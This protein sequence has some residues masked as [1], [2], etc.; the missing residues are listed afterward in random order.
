MEFP[1]LCEELITL[2][3]ERV[4]LTS[5]VGDLL[6]EPG[7]IPAESGDLVSDGGGV[8]VHD[9]LLEII[10][11]LKAKKGNLPPLFFGNSE[12]KADIYITYES[13]CQRFLQLF[14]KN[15]KF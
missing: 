7:S 5:E 11:S 13:P 2:L 15:C 14:R 3:S 6:A 8:V 12:R 1:V 9:F 4:A 10:D